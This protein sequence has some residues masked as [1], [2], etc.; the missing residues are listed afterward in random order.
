MVPFEIDNLL[1]PALSRAGNRGNW[2][3]NYELEIHRLV[4]V[5]KQDGPV[6]DV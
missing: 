3:S 4:L 5:A 1:L 2:D 6:S